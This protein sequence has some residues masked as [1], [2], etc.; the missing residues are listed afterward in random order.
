MSDS[1]TCNDYDATTKSPCYQPAFANVADLLN[2]KA[3]AGFVWDAID[4]SD[5]QFDDLALKVMFLW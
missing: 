2:E 1:N 3:T 5:P 4:V